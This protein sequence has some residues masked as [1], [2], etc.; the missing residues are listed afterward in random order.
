MNKME[1]NVADLVI[2]CKVWGVP[3][4]PPIIA[5][6][7]WLDN[8]NSFDQLA[9]CLQQHYYIIAVDLPGHG[10]SSHLPKGVHYHFIDG[11][12]LVLQIIN[13]LQLD[14]VHLLGHSLGACLASMIAGIAPER[15]LSLSLIEGLGPLTRSEESAQKQLSQYLQYLTQEKVKKYKGYAQFEHAALARSLK[16]YVSRDIAKILCERG[17]IKKKG[18]YY[19]RHDPRLLASSPLQMTEVQVLSCLEQ[20][21]AKTFLLWASEGFS[22]NY[23]LIAKRIMTVKHLTVERMSGGHHIHME[24]PEAVAQLLADFY[25]TL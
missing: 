24:Q 7:G 8:A 17:L 19:W 6:H 11:L 10:H 2:A 9:E 4:N 20:I 13:A 21:Q 3:E 5:L 16:G 14:K 23:Q 22:F 15:F 18:Y 12:F 25:K 1:L